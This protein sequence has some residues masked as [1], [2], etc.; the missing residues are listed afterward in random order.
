MDIEDE[1]DE[2]EGWYTLGERRPLPSERVYCA[3][4]M[5]T[6]PLLRLLCSGSALLFMTLSLAIIAYL[7]LKV[8]QCTTPCTGSTQWLCVLHW[9]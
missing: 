8:L 2:R 5:M 4:S 9:I 1:E 3:R 7:H 6:L